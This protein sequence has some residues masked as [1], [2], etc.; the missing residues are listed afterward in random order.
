MGEMLNR[1]FN[2]DN[3]VFRFFQTI[4]YIW[5]LHILWLVCSLP[6]ITLGASTTALC[7]SCMKLHRKE[8]YVTRNFFHS[9]RENFGQATILF[10]FF[11][12]TGGIL[13]FDFMICGQMDA[14]IGGF[15]RCGAA[16]LLIPYGMTLLYAFAVQARFVNPPG[17]TLRYALLVSGKYF[18]YTFQMMLVA[19]AVLF[20]N[21][22]IVLVNF[23]T[24]SF[25][26]GMLMYI[27]T[28][29]YEK[30]FTE[31]IWRSQEPSAEPQS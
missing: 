30:I 15:F 1:I 24:L 26:V 5:W 14:A 2:V 21:T 8:G 27:L 7:Y 25:G 3:A 13:L 18:R 16:A 4:G 17:K 9:F 6:V 31:L 12:I 19:A 23:V 28:F 10:L 11:L 22:T 20:L 29:F